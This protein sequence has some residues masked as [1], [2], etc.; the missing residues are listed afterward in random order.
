MTGKK[1]MGRARN[2]IKTYGRHRQRVITSDI[3]SSDDEKKLDCRP[4]L[5]S[6]SSSSMD[7]STANSTSDSLFGGPITSQRL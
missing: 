1:N 4:G 3:W 6:S 5:F 2:M 7:S